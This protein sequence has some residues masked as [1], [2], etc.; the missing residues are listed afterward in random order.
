MKQVGFWK[1][2]RKWKKGE[3]REEGRLNKVISGG[4]KTKAVKSLH[5]FYAIN[6][7]GGRNFLRVVGPPLEERKEAAGR[8]RRV[9]LKHTHT[10]TLKV[11]EK[12]LASLMLSMKG[13]KG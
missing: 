10:H 13:R 2:E 5:F 4:S 12:W 11:R 7:K 8:W 1:R 9:K 3:R 6:E